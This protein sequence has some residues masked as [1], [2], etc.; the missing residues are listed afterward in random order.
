MRVGMISL[1]GLASVAAGCGV[2]V[3]GGSGD[4]QAIRTAARGVIEAI[5]DG[6]AAKQCGL[7]AT[8]TLDKVG[9]TVESCT[10]I[11]E[12]EAGVYE[13]ISS[14]LPRAGEVDSAEVEIDGDRAKVRFEDGSYVD[15]ANEDGAW[16]Y[17]HVQAN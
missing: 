15:L 6:D 5:H 16:K 7:A 1:L 4:E 13:L 11:T 17:V 2:Q 10:E 8:E 12:K 14:E 9:G 3:G